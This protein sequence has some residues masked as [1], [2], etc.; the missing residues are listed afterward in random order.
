MQRVN[1]DI[2]RL[3]EI[4][5]IFMK[6]AIPE[7]QRGKEILEK[8]ADSE[9]IEVTSHWK[10]PELHGNAGSIRIAGNKIYSDRW[11][12]SAVQKRIKK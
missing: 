11:H 10:I 3:I 1:S 4:D 7:F 12:K 9:L 5:R 2:N 8:Y 6:P